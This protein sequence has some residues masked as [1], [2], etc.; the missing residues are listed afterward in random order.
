M[1]S[2]EPQREPEGCPKGERADL[3]RRLLYVR[4]TKGGR[5]RVVPIHPAL[6]PLFA[7]YYATRV[8]LI[9]QALFVDVQGKPLNYTQLGQAF[10]TT[11]PRRASARESA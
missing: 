1:S 9:E 4:K 8:P 5:Q 2:G 7:A 6:A 11:S 10:A 3:S